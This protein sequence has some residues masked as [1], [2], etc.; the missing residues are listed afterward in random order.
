M[1]IDE[2]LYGPCICTYN[3]KRFIYVNAIKAIYGCLKSALLFYQLFSGELKKW[4]FKQNPYDACTFN[5]MTE[6]SQLTIVFHVDD[7]KIS[8]MK[9]SAV[10]HLLKQLSDRFGKETPLTVT[11]GD[12]H[13][14][15]GMTIDFSIKGNVKF[16]MF[17]YI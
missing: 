14:Y 4:G 16:Y 6:G 15:L 10:D 11:R 9:K 3:N 1:T 5:K 2:N 12:V 17:D 13:D 7:C 8:H